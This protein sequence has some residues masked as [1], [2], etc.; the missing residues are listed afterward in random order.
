MDSC[1][2]CIARILQ[3]RLASRVVAAVGMGGVRKITVVETSGDCFAQIISRDVMQTG[4]L[5][6]NESLL[7]VPKQTDLSAS[8]P[9]G[10]KEK[11]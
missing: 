10:N 9:T 7:H 1:H 3:Y 11:L 2:Y 6:E 8:E 5:P 4:F